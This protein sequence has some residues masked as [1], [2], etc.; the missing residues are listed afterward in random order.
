M[1]TSTIKGKGAIYTAPWTA[2]SSNASNTRVTG[3]VTIPAGTYVILLKIPEC[4]QTNALAFGPDYGDSQIFAKSQSTG[5][6]FASFNSSHDLY[7]VCGMSQPTNYSYIDR[8]S[9]KAIR[10]S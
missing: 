5:V 4:S 1:A 10:I 2:T 6:Y 7:A 9:I 3:T 8:G